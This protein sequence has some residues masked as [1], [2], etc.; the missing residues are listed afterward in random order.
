MVTKWDQSDV[1]VD[2]VCNDAARL[3]GLTPEEV[4]RRLSGVPKD[5]PTVISI[6]HNF[7]ESKEFSTEFSEDSQ[8]E[9]RKVLRLFENVLLSEDPAATP[10]TVTT[11]LIKTVCSMRV[12]S[13]S[14]IARNGNRME[15]DFDTVAGT[16][17]DKRLG[18]LQGLA[19]WHRNQPNVTTTFEALRDVDAR[20]GSTH[21]VAM[22]DSQAAKFL[23]ASRV[24]RNRRRKEALASLLLG[25]GIRGFECSALN[26]GCI[27]WENKTLYLYVFKGWRRSKVRFQ[28]VPIP[29][30]TLS[31]LHVYLSDRFGDNPWPLDA[32]LFVSERGT[33]RK[34]II[35]Y[36][37]TTSA[38]NQIVN[39]LLV[40]AGVSLTE[41]TQSGRTKKVADG[42]G[43][44]IT[45][46]TYA[47]WIYRHSRYDLLVVKEALRH[48]NLSTTEIYI[49]SFG[50][51]VREIAQTLGEFFETL[52]PHED[53]ALNVRDQL[54]MGR[55]S[56]G[57]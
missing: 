14:P 44:H 48:A 18:I 17:F 6:I 30:W 3:F 10:S 47:M 50:E 45:R 9:Y 4:F 26:V 37:L 28:T 16:T 34:G 41:L 39:N 36:R 27:D 51:H 15:H 32:P 8:D 19:K 33:L 55:R 25:T 57:D 21:R 46:H 24:G 22:T 43:V 49:D 11:S 2:Q 54:R 23:A 29:P 56:S 53:V 40:A 1:N 38:I 42:N 31:A 13:V 12:G 20:G 5:E 7:L 35:S 52:A